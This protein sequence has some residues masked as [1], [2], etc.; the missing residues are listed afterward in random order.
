[1][2]SQTQ[3]IYSVPVV[4][5]EGQKFTLDQPADSLISAVL[6]T[7]RWLNCQHSVD[8]EMIDR[9][10][11]TRKSS[12]SKKKKNSLNKNFRPYIRLNMQ[13]LIVCGLITCVSER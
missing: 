6:L 2:S 7:H 1:M 5:D 12:L 10:S 4:D 3:T 13:L 9:L 11:R 8:I